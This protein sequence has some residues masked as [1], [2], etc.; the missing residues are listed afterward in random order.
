M[1]SIKCI[2]VKQ[3]LLADTGR[4]G[5]SVVHCGQLIYSLNGEL[6]CDTA[7]GNWWLPPRGAIWI[8]RGELHAA[9]GSG[10]ITC[11]HLYEDERMPPFCA[12]LRPTALLA[13]LLHRA[14]HFS[15][16]AQLTQR[17][18]RLLATL[19]DELAVAT[20][21][22]CSLPLPSDGRLNKLVTQLMAAPADKTPAA[23]WA[24]RIGMSERNMSRQLLRET[25]MSLG[26]W[27]RQLHIVLALQQLRQGDAV[28]NVALTLGYESPSGFITMFRKITGKSPGRYLAEE[29]SSE[30]CSD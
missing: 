7:Q 23:E 15:H 10:E 14:A 29:R 12:T 17:Q 4:P 20:T 25:G 11:F 5:H 27:R 28:Q 24:R 16:D 6:R 21:E 2:S 3:R 1:A 30:F 26:R 19:Q 8:P 22:A 18:T 9:S 13:E